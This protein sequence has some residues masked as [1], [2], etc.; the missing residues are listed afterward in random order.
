[1]KK[2]QLLARILLGL[3]YFIFG[4]NGFLNFIQTPP[5]PENIQAFMNGLIS[6]GYFMPVVKGT[7]VICGLMLLLNLA[8]P[9]ALV[10][11]APVT[12]HILLFH[13][14]MTPG[15]Q[16]QVMPL[17]MVVLHIMIA[18]QYWDKYKPLFKSK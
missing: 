14:M 4:L 3:I 17:V 12:L 7:E 18:L 5:M 9:L 1:M 2:I 15:L 10:I 16:N 13:G 11:L 6:T 8:T